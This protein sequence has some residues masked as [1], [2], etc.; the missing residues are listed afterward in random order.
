MFPKWQLVGLYLCVSVAF[1]CSNATMECWQ[2]IGLLANNSFSTTKCSTTR[3][4]PVCCL[5]SYVAQRQGPAE[6]IEEAKPGLRAIIEDSFQFEWFEWFE[7]EFPT[8]PPLIQQWDTNQSLSQWMYWH[9]WYWVWLEWII[10]MTELE[11][12]EL[13]CSDVDLCFR[14]WCNVLGL[15][16]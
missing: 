2:L 11:L 1:Q 14:V 6:K 13:N 15:L 8:T 7:S 10:K 3:T 12:I 9:T 4:F 16:F 5:P